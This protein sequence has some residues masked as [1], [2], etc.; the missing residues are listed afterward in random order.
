LKFKEYGIEVR[1]ICKEPYR[2]ECSR[3][4]V[5]EIMKISGSIPVTYEDIFVRK[6]FFETISAVYLRTYITWMIK[7]PCV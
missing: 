4:N 5:S 1:I 2:F 6:G 7:G 3:K